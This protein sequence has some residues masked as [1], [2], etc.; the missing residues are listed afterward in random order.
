ME[1]D[2]K[3]GQS[4]WSWSFTFCILLL[5]IVERS[6]FKNMINR[7]SQPSSNYFEVVVVEVKNCSMYSQTVKDLTI[8]ATP[9]N[10]PCILQPLY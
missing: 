9:V 7:L 8:H 10:Q 2:Q 3:I 1:A 6:T 4:W 5:S